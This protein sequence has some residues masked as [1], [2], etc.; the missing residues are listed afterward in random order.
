[1]KTKQLIFST[2]LNL[3]PLIIT[4]SYTDSSGRKV[5]REV[6]S[7]NIKLNTQVQWSKKVLSLDV[8]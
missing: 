2:R 1:M 7:G 8:Y 4:K 6:I 3:R 5:C